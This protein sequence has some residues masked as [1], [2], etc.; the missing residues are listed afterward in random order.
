GLRALRDPRRLNRRWGLRMAQYLFTS[1]SHGVGGTFLLDSTTGATRKLL[2]GSFR[3][4]TSGP[5][6]CYYGVTG[7]RHTDYGPNMVHRAVIYRIEPGT[8]KAEAVAEHPVGDTHDL[9]WFNGH[10]YLV[11]SLGNQ[12]I[13]LD[14]R[15]RWLDRMQIVEDERDVCHVNCLE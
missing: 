5:D 7:T 13:R 9:L 10:F 6:G 3:G 8:W 15:C 4:I 2:A 12:I 11:A 1:S 14:E